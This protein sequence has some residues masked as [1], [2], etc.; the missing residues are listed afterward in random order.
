MNLSLK[1]IFKEYKKENKKENKKEFLR[2]SYMFLKFI[3]DKVL[4]GEEVTLLRLGT[5]KVTGRKQEIKY[6][7]DGNVK[8][9]APNWAKTKK[10]WSINEEAKN[11][12]KVIYNT[13]E[14]SD[15]IRYKYTWVKKKL[16]LKF[17][18][19]Y[20]LQLSRENKRKLYRIINSGKDYVTI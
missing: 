15:G 9:L 19:L 13:N 7:E 4:E 14:H 12:K 17:K 1:D 18:T 8:G 20:A 5:L 10:L 11:K 3:I 16:I 6:D 2:I